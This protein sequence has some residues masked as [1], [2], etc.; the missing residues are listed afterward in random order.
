MSRNPTALPPA[1]LSHYFTPPSGY[2]GHFGWVCGYSADREF[3]ND[4]AER[5]TQQIKA[6][7][8]SEGRVKLVVMLDH[9]HAEP[10]A[11][12]VPAVLRLA[13]TAEQIAKRSFHLLHAKVAILGFRA[14]GNNNLDSQGAAE[15]WHL[16]LVVSTGNWT[17]QTL[18]DSLDL[19]WSV[20]LA[21]E[22]LL[23]PSDEVRD[24]CADFKASWHFMSQLFKRFEHDIL[25][26]CPLGRP[27]PSS[28]L[29]HDAL[30]TWLEAVSAEAAES[31][32][33]FF[34]NRE[35]SFINQ[36]QSKVEATGA[37]TKRNY[38]VMGSGFFEEVADE[39]TVP[40][41]LDRIVNTLQDKLLTDSA[42]RVVVNPDACQAVAG[43]YE[44]LHDHNYKIRSAHVS[45]DC[46]GKNAIRSLHAKFIYSGYL[47]G[48]KFSS[49]W[50]YLG[51]GNLTNRGFM[52]KASSHRG[53]LE[54]GVVFAT[55]NLY[56]KPS[57]S[58]AVAELISNCL[59]IHFN[60][61]VFDDKQLKAGEEMPESDQL[62]VAAPVSWLYWFEGTVPDQSYLQSP[63][64][65][66]TDFSVVKDDNVLDL[67]KDGRC[68][69]IGEQ[70]VQVI[71]IWQANGKEQRAV[72]PV[73]DQLGRLAAT[74]LLPID[75][76]ELFW[77]LER[78][79]AP[80]EDDEPE[81]LD[82]GDFSDLA[83]AVVAVQPAAKYAIR[84]MM[85]LVEHIAD[86]Q[87][88]LAERD[89]SIWCTR[90]EQ[91]LCQTA[92][93]E[94]FIACI[95]MFKDM[96]VN[97]LSP[98][99]HPPFRPE[100]AKDGST[101]AGIEYEQTIKRIEQRWQVEELNRIAPTIN[102]DEQ[103]IHHG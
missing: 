33:R 65:S 96:E 77:Q 55:G 57:S 95:G 47:R 70:P 24:T 15:R 30:A 2:Y 101:A 38:L 35:E 84:Q 49:G 3:L 56:Q 46:F 102:S 79:P 51:S 45:E 27:A 39:N 32:P 48:D 8:A 36:L 63:D 75:M 94:S 14:H 80:V 18:E 73:M 1:A 62:F 11:A 25:S 71:L 21:S 28:A 60:D 76:D 93:H 87:C 26:A 66:V 17:I 50:L 81:S 59:P 58:V 34:D 82:E 52:Y 41:V 40:S 10:Q 5:F 85:A 4:A 7:R 16:R 92:K 97:P 12:D 37:V 20:D 74:K 86:K 90:L 67:D 83:T 23:L 64:A 13:M 19:V 53:N 6:R 88:M 42:E 103:E 99:T 31:K 78:Y 91:L 68:N 44:A 9:T 98:L 54:A 69:W 72:V 89:W 22:D 100:Y 29:P 61:E 43:S